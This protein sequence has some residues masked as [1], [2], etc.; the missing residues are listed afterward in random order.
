MNRL[1]IIGAGGHGKVIADIARL[2][3]YED[4]VFLDDDAEVKTCSGYPVIGKCKDVDQVDAD[5]VIAIGDSKIR[6]KLQERLLPNKLVTL[7]HPKAVIADDVSIGTGT[8]VMAGVIINPG[9]K[10]GDGCIINTSSSVDHDSEIGNY[11][12]IAVGS[13]LCG[14]VNIGDE[15]WIG[16]GTIISNNISV[17]SRCI[18][19]AGAVVVKDLPNEGTYIGIPARLISCKNE[20][21]KLN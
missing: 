14:S 4:I 16:A 18:I 7:I 5:I 15:T 6:K 9:V 12:H 20:I 13:H 10:I 21:M 2:N 19:G 1:A 8:V 17:T 11:V 3:G